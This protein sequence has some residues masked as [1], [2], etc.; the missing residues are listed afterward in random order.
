MPTASEITTAG[1]NYGEEAPATPTLPFRK[2][3]PFA[4]RAFLT[5][6]AALTALPTIPSRGDT[7]RELFNF[8]KLN[9]APYAAVKK[10]CLTSDDPDENETPNP[11]I[12]KKALDITKLPDFDSSLSQQEQEQLLWR[13]INFAGDY[14]NNQPNPD[15]IKRW[16]RFETK[17][18]TEWVAWYY[19]HYNADDFID[20]PGF[21]KKHRLARY[22]L[23]V[24][25]HTDS[26]VAG[27]RRIDASDYLVAAAKDH[28]EE[29][30]IRIWEKALTPI[31]AS[32]WDEAVVD[33]AIRDSKD[34]TGARAIVPEALQRWNDYADALER[35]INLLN[36]NSSVLDRRRLTLIKARVAVAETQI[37]Q[38]NP[39]TV[40]RPL[41]LNR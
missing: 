26:L 12:P 32:Q 10:I 7:A 28:I 29:S 39:R 34:N 2:T 14:A 35:Y 27:G 25:Y 4:R 20:A 19:E 3:G 21:D 17:L 6:A 1:R 13:A 30:W 37:N 36:S 41:A 11:T 16:H 15:E 38:G 23:V 31:A 9:P 18:T 22:W 5:L 8:F 24:Q 33:S 40:P